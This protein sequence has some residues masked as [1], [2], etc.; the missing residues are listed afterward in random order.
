MDPASL[1]A[2]A[3]GVLVPYLAE[4]GKEVAKKAGGAAWEGTGKLW[5]LVRSKLAKPGECQIFC[6]SRVRGLLDIVRGGP[7]DG[8]TRR[9]F[10]RAVGRLREA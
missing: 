9:G 8:Y 1:A 2:G 4:A 6:V 7:G 10:G 5:T 3:V